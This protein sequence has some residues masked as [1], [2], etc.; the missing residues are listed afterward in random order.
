MA[1]T[2]EQKLEEAIE[3]ERRR[4][5]KA[6]ADKTLKEGGPEDMMIA[7]DTATVEIDGVPFFIKRGETRARRGDRL[8]QESPHLWR[9]ADSTYADVEQATSNPGEKR[10]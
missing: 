2:E 8:V 10:G 3:K 5:I 9:D 6:L 7:S 1:K 4:E